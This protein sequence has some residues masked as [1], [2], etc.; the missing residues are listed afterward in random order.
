MNFSIIRQQF[1]QEINQ[2]DAQINLDIAALCIA[3]GEFP[4]LDP[5]EYLNALDTMAMEVQERLQGSRYPLKVIQTINQYLFEELG[6]IGN[7]DNYYD[8]WNSYLNQ[9]IERRTGIPI[10]LSIVYLEIAKR[11]DF[12]M[13]GIGMPGHFLIRP[14]FE[15]SGIYVDAFNQGEV[16]FSEDC[17][18]RL[19]QVYNQ[20]VQLKPE[21]LK[22]VSSRQILARMLTNLKIIYMNLEKFEI[23]VSI[24]E[25]ILLLFPHTITEKRDRGILY[26]Q[27]NRWTEARQDLE[28]YL[29][30]FP[31]AQDASVIRQ[32]L[33]RIPSFYS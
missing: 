8:P 14:D 3:Q 1:Y 16:L 24:I 26:Y 20:P 33:A 19:S 31:N 10:T 17:E 22:S 28:D 18:A 30:Q 4:Q 15:E 12:P 32:L 23:A 2:P 6:F 5:Q 25:L 7:Q 13:V 11:I 27:L 9:V 29:Q 21:F